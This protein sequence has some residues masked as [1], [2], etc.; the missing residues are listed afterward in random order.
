MGKLAWIAQPVLPGFLRVPL[1]APLPGPW[2]C[3]H[4]LTRPSLT[5]TLETDGSGLSQETYCGGA[6]AGA[7]ICSL[8]WLC[9]NLL[10]SLVLF[11]ILPLFCP[12]CCSLFCPPCCSLLCSP[13][14]FLLCSSVGLLPLEKPPSQQHLGAF[15]GPGLVLGYW[16]NPE[17]P[18]KCWAPGE[19]ETSVPQAGGS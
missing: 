15:Q 19:T 3:W 7:G 18:D 17:V 1:G 12:P 5:P 8:C 11:P 4:P 2:G 10:L 13:C 9:M 6:A 14:F 16:M